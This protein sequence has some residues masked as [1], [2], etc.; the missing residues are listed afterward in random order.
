MTEEFK[1]FVG[2]EWEGESNLD[3]DLLTVELYD[4]MGKRLFMKEFK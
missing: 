4:D 2:P 1:N 3:E